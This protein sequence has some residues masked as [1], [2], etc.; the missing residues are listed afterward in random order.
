MLA[1]TMKGG[2]ELKTIRGT[3][4]QLQTPKAEQGFAMWQLARDSGVLEPNSSYAYLMFAKFFAETC[5]LAVEDGTPIGFVTGFIPP[6]SPQILFVWQ[7]GVSAAHRGKG[8]GKHMLREL[9]RRL[10]SKSVCYLEA[11]VTMSN[12][13]SKALFT[14][15]AN[16]YSARYQ[17]N[18]CFSAEMFPEGGHEAEWTYR[19]GPI[20][21]Q[22]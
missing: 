1:E 9:L 2:D 7:I 8:I 11:T 16:E 15:L 20:P 14:S 6:G 21:I 17:I 5:V 18:E 10:E 19:V 13:A 22:S 4:I 3:R 12:D